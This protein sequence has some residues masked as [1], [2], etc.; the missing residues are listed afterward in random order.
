MRG[1]GEW[2][3]GGR[4]VG[5]GREGQ[6]LNAHVHGRADY[7]NCQSKLGVSGR[8]AQLTV[9]SRIGSLMTANAVPLKFFDMP[10]EHCR[11]I[12][13]RVQTQNMYAD[14]KL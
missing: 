12:C 2:M 10:D 8:T 6:S 11:Q 5:E 4:G 3:R 14:V 13:W 7:V 9:R 1:G